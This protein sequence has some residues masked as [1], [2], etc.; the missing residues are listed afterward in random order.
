MLKVALKGVA[1][2]IS[3]YC[4]YMVEHNS[5]SKHIGA[6]VS[7]CWVCGQGGTISDGRWRSCS[8]RLEVDAL[9]HVASSSNYIYIY[10]KTKS[11][12]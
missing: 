10:L 9:I 6:G 8:V 1:L 7:V 3:I 4:S 12:L 5:A 2:L 11:S